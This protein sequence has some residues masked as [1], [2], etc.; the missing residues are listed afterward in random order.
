MKRRS[1]DASV[2]SNSS[3]IKGYSLSPCGVGGHPRRSRC[4]R[5]VCRR[6]SSAVMCMET[7]L[8]EQWRDAAAAVSDPSR[9]TATKDL[10][11]TRGSS[12]RRGAAFAGGCPGSTPYGRAPV[13]VVIMRLHALVTR[14]ITATMCE[15]CHSRGIRRAVRSAGYRPTRLDRSGRRYRPRG[16]STRLVTRI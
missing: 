3:T 6:P 9:I 13:V 1:A 4:N 8:S 5:R 14:W 7:A 2:I 12:G 16:S 10:R 11:H 15:A